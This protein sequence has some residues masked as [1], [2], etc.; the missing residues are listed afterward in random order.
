VRSPV[1]SADH[2]P[3]FLATH[4]GRTVADRSSAA[5]A[6]HLTV[7][8]SAEFGSQTDNGTNG[9]SSCYS[10]GDQ[11]LRQNFCLILM[12]VMTTAEHAIKISPGTC[13]HGLLA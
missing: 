2:H 6:V 4:D 10:T 7:A 1:V 11:S 3:H 8:G 12:V 5:V 9:A 13:H